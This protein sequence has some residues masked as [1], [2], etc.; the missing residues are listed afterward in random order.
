MASHEDLYREMVEQEEEADRRNQQALAMRELAKKQPRPP[1]R[2]AAEERYREKI[3][4]VLETRRRIAAGLPP[5][6]NPLVNLYLK[7]TGRD[8]ISELPKE[9]IKDP[10][11]SFGLDGPSPEEIAKAIQ[12]N[13]E[14]FADLR[15]APEAVRPVAAV[16]KSA[17]DLRHD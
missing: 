1:R 9:E 3:L 2:D 6:T 8:R 11:K 4:P 13:P 10:A 15:R 7:I 5:T 16:R 14:A 17:Q 12:E